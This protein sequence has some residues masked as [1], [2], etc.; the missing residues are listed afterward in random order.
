MKNVKREYDD[1]EVEIPDGW[2]IL[3]KD[4]TILKTDELFNDQICK[5]VPVRSSAGNFP[6]NFLHCNPFV[7]QIEKENMTKLP[8]KIAVH[9]PTVEIFEAVQKIAFRHGWEWINNTSGDGILKGWDLEGNNTVIDF[10]YAKG[11]R[12]FGTNSRTT[13]IPHWDK[14]LT[15]A[16]IDIIEKYLAAKPEEEIKVGDWVVCIEGPS[17]KGAGWQANLVFIVTKINHLDSGNRV[18]FEGFNRDGV[19]KESA[20]RATPEEIKK[21]QEENEIKIQ[22]TK[23]IFLAQRINWNSSVVYVDELKAIKAAMNL[24]I[25]AS[26]ITIDHGKKEIRVG[27]IKSGDLSFETAEKIFKKMGI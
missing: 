27:C 3:E 20:R 12:Q 2:R 15:L 16:D 9:C 25:G 17:P 11:R 6:R 23:V 4:E 8:E 14:L 21:Y 19:F 26:P 13:S 24:K 22:G 18:Y 5:F 7:R 10:G 1:K